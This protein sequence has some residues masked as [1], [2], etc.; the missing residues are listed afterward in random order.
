M[1][2]YLGFCT[3][4][5]LPAAAVATDYQCAYGDK[6]RRI[7]IVYEPGRA[8]PCEVHYY[9]DTEAP[10]ER[11]VLWRAQN[12]AG[13]CEART[14]ELVARL[15]GHGWECEAAVDAGDDSEDLAPPTDI[16]ARP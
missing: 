16:E 4:L 8:V 7:E 10:G 6:Q 2:R 12:E 15:R 9:K 3:A 1:K 13:Y 5:L 11:E 14:E